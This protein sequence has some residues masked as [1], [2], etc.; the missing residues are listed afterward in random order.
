MRGFV[1]AQADHAHRRGW[2]QGLHAGQKAQTCTQDGHQGQVLAT[3]VRYLQRA[4]PSVHGDG[5]GGQVTGGFERQQGGDF[6][7]ELPEMHRIGADVAQLAKFVTHQRVVDFDNF[8]AA[9]LQTVSL[10]TE[11]G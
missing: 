3:H 1:A 2:Q 4:G 5:L 8:H 9:A 7:G 6:T 10:Q 11:T